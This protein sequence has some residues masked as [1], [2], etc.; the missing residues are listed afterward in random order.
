MT[1]TGDNKYTFLEYFDILDWELE[2]VK[3]G[4]DRA[5]ADKFRFLPSTQARRMINETIRELVALCPKRFEKEV[6]FRFHHNDPENGYINIEGDTYISSD[7]KTFTVPDSIMKV[8]AIKVDDVWSVLEDSSSNADIFSPASNQIYNADG[9]TM[10]EPGVTGDT[11][12]ARVIMHPPKITGTTHTVTGVSEGSTTA[13]TFGFAIDFEVGDSAVVTNVTPATFNSTQT[14]IGVDERKYRVITDLDSSALTYTSGGT[15][16]RDAIVDFPQEYIRLLT[17]EIKRKAWARKGRKM[18]E[19]EY[20]ELM[21]L[22]GR[23]ERETGRVR[24]KS[25]F[26]AEGYGFGR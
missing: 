6:V 15:V 13:Y 20:S 23:W 14:V 25:I 4:V 9:W 16:T 11:L 24:S 8:I 3:D 7:L 2:Q 21:A 10:Y 18:S 1:T 5:S 12:K 22:K 19:F 26:A 17:L